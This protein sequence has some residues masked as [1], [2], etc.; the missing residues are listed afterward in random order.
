MIV[1]VHGG[2]F[3]ASPY[4][5][6]L[7][8]RHYYLQ[9][10]YNLLIINYRG[11]IGYGKQLMHSL[12]GQ[13]GVN[14][15]HDCGELTL[16]AISHFSDR[17]DE[18]KVG[19]TGGSH[20]GFL[21]GWLTGHPKYKDIWRASVTRN[22]VYDMNYMNAQTDI[23]DWIHACVFGE[24]IDLAQITK[25]QVATIYERSPISVVHNVQCPSCIMIGDVDLRVPPA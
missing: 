3:S 8:G 15:V 24:Q 21:T 6:F 18:N 19:L 13:I 7:A 5:M 12:L 22:A 17:I 2:P 1:I 9:A 10:G 16:K 23:P 14:D 4:Q 11:S 25:E 20:G